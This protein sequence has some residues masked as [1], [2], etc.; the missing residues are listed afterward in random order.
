MTM[1]QSMCLTN[2]QAVRYS[3]QKNAQFRTHD[4]TNGFSYVSTQNQAKFQCLWIVN[5]TLPNED[6][7]RIDKRGN[8]DFRSTFK[9][10]EYSIWATNHCEVYRKS[11]F[12]LLSILPKSSF[13][14]HRILF[15]CK[16]FAKG[17]H[18]FC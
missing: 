2:S 16:G 12:H 10:C 8:Q 7:G 15:F 3:E 13:G 14:E 5:L 6:F 1:S 9:G 11:G 18:K 4:L 17:V